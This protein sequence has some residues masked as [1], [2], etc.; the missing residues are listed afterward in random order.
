MNLKN[1]KQEIIKNRYKLLENTLTKGGMSKTYFAEDLKSRKEVVIK[2]FKGTSEKERSRFIREIKI[3]KKYKNSGFIIPI[4]DFDDRY[5]PPFF[6]MPKANCDLLA[7]GKL[8]TQDSKKYFY[9]MLECVE[10]IH[11]NQAFHRDIKPDNFLIY[12]GTV[13]CSDFGL[14]KDTQ[15]TQLTKS[16]EFWGTEYYMPPEFKTKNGFQNP[17]ESS[18][19]YSLGKSNLKLQ[20]I[21]SK[22]LG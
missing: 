18:D 9:K 21:L 10:F 3:L 1:S 19:I 2:F 16:K 7:L 20:K 15:S 11:N 6:V 4:L 12:K 17:Q 22:Q 13:V 14:A 5:N 8:S